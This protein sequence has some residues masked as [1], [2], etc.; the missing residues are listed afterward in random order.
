M[1]ISFFFFSL[2]NV[3]LKYA[4]NVCKNVMRGGFALCDANNDT[5]DTG[6]QAK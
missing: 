4:G 1:I 6:R 2:S 5:G 3:A